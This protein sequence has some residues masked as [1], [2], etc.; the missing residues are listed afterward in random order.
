[1]DK[2][3]ALRLLK[4]GNAAYVANQLNGNFS[5]ERRKELVEGQHPIAVVVACSDSRVVP[6]AIFNKGLGEIF[7][8]RVAG[9]VV[10]EHELGSIL[11]AVNH[12][13]SNLVVILG[14][15]HCGAVHAA[16][17]GCTEEHIHTLTDQIIENVGD[18]KDVTLASK[19]NAKKTAE[20]VSLN[21][22]TG[23]L[24]VPALFDIET[25]IVEFLD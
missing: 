15:T 22:K 19:I 13:H 9:N 2:F 10:G 24:V 5:V 16:L 7:V 3:E 6:E 23:T 18:I 14:H 4:D 20:N 25:G 17:S 12:C 11:Y 1:M 8:I 21:V